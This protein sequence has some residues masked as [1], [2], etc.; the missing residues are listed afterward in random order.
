MVN[1]DYSVEKLYHNVDMV[2]KLQK[3]D[4]NKKTL[5]ELYYLSQKYNSFI[6]SERKSLL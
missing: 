5:S 1:S 6:E 3:I 4:C 2:D